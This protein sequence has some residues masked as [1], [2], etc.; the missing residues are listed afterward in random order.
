MMKGMG[1]MERDSN[2]IMGVV[3]AAILAILVWIGFA[4]LLFIVPMQ[5]EMYADFGAPLSTGMQLLFET[6]DFLKR[7]MIFL[8]PALMIL[9]VLPFCFSSR[10]DG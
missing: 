6:S 4:Y 8:F 5:A 9:T 2:D 10:K 3:F 7:Y 1:D